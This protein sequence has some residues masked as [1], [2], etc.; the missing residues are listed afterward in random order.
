[1][2]LDEVKSKF[3]K[4]DKMDDKYANKYYQKAALYHSQKKIQEEVM[5]Y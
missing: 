1:M 3:E 4:V 5:E 2:P